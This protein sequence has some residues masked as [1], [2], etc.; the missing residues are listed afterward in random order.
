MPSSSTSMTSSSSSR[1][2]RS[3]IVPSGPLAVLVSVVEQVVDHASDE[4]GVAPRWAGARPELDREGPMSGAP[5][6]S[7]RPIVRGARSC[8]CAPRASEAS[9][10]PPSA[11]QRRAPAAPM[12]A[13]RRRCAR[14]PRGPARCRP[15]TRRPSSGPPR[16]RYRARP[17][18]A[19]AASGARARRSRGARA[20]RAAAARC[21][22][23]CR[24]RPAPPR[25][26]RRAASSLRAGV[27]LA[28]SERAG[29]L[30]QRR[31]RLART[32]GAS[33]HHEHTPTPPDDGS[34]RAPRRTAAGPASWRAHR[35][36]SRR[37][38]TSG[39]SA[40]SDDRARV[41]MRSA[42]TRRGRRRH[43]RV[44]RAVREA[45]LARQAR[46]GASM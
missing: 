42:R 34:R 10:P 27:E 13:R 7:S 43:L 40:R 24:R 3:M 9:R 4:H 6:G 1:R 2:A 33:Q 29:R 45:W 18:C 17:G 28:L 8:R 15:A 26:S 30:G 35:G 46:S 11:C 38:P 19:R 20:R 41:A 5:H 21:D 16:S 39:D 32:C 25:R 12:R 14:A 44:R 31:E 23:P 36:A 22:R 37:P